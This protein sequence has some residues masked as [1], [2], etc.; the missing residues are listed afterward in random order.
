MSVQS[1]KRRRSLYG[2][3]Y[4]EE[5][6]RRADPGERKTYN[7][8]QVWQRNHEILRLTLL[9]H[10]AA[11]IANMLSIHPTTVSNTINSKLGMEKLSAMR[12]ARD[13][14]T[15]D[16][17][18]EVEKLYEQA[19]VIYREILSDK[20]VS[21]SLRKQT[22]DT[23]LMDIG[24]YRAPSK[25]E[26]R[27]AHAHLTSEELEEIKRRGRAAAL[28]SGHAIDIAPKLEVESAEK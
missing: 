16:V 18:K 28:A 4:R 3:E 10:K 19:V 12:L 27:V 17:A 25:F 21:M 11:A 15:I 24:G 20:D 1:T 2:F 14:E 22:A 7:I 9:G 26:G 8:K 5:D 6:G 13:A 23:V